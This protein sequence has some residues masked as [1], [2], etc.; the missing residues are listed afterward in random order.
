MAKLE[1]RYLVLPDARI[2]CHEH[3]NGPAFLLLHGSSESKRIF[4]RYRI[5]HF[6]MF[7]TLAM[8][9]RGRGQSV[10][11][12]ARYSIAQYA[13][14]AIDPCQSKGITRASVVGD[15]DGGNIALH[16]A[17]KRPDLFTRTVAVSPNSLA[18]GIEEGWLRFFRGVTS[19]WILYDERDMI[20]EEHIREMARLVPGATTGKIGHCN[21]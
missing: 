11:H 18:S 12:D 17:R 10:S 19:L 6:G 8:D 21:H 5:I 13:Q 14:D 20:K 7:R 3:G 2:A 9:S 1:T 16:L 15:S 4:S